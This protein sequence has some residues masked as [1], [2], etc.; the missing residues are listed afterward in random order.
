MNL[1]ILVI[2]LAL[3]MCGVTHAQDQST[4]WPTISQ[5]INQQGS[6]VV[7]ANNDNV[8]ILVVGSEGRRLYVCTYNDVRPDFQSRCAPIN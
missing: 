7:S 2:A 4:K 6:E 1:R 3:V 8:W 5:L